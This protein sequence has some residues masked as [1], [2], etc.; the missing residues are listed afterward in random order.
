V[1]GRRAGERVEFNH[2]MLTDSKI[3]SPE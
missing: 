2:P 3:F 1:P